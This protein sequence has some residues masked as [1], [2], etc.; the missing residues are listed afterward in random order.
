MPEIKTDFNRGGEAMD[1]IDGKSPTFA[2]LFRDGV[3]D[4]TAIRNALIGLLQKL[5]LDAG[6]TDTDYESSLTPAA[7]KNTK[8]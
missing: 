4:V 5:D 3:D 6:V 1:P 7:L 2:D 8:G